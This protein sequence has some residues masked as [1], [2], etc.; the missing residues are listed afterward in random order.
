VALGGG[1]QGVQRREFGSELGAA[2]LFVEFAVAGGLAADRAG[3]TVDVTGGADDAA[4]GGDQG[5]DFVALGFVESAR[6]AVRRLGRLRRGT[7]GWGLGLG[8]ELGSGN[9]GWGLGCQK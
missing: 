7:G 5:A 6:A 1:A 9:M 2:E 3:G 4:P 8:S